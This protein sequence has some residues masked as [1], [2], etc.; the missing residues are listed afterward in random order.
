[1]ISGFFAY[2]Q[3]RGGTIRHRPHHAELVDAARRGTV[4]GCG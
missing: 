4:G 1:M 2:L 3:A